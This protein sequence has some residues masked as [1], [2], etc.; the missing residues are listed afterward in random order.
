MSPKPEPI[1]RRQR[2]EQLAGDLGIDQPPSISVRP[3]SV[4][5]T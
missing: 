4:S 1:E 3:S 5:M 2:V